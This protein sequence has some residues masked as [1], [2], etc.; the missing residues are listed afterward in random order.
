MKWISFK[1]KTPEDGQ[2]IKIKTEAYLEGQ[3]RYHNG[4]IIYAK[5]D[6]VSFG[7]I[8]HWM[9]IEED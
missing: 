5:V 9:P 3:G 1:D 7:E 6:G 8:T 4:A 2:R